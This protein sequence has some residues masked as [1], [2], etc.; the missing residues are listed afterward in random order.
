MK[1]IPPKRSKMATIDLSANAIVTAIRK[2][3][4]KFTKDDIKKFIRVNGI[5]HVNFMYAGGDGRL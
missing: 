1:N 4:E 5:R 3:R 2:P